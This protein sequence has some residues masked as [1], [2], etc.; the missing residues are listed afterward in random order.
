MPGV[1]GTYPKADLDNAI[2]VAVAK[3][4]EIARVRIIPTAHG[5]RYEI[6]TP[7]GMGAAIDGDADPH[8]A[9]ELDDLLPGNK[10]K[11]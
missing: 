2:S 3:G 7:A 6:I 8:G 4:L 10:D 9:D 1:K 5:P 11:D